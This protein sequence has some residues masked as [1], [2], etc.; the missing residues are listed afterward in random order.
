MPFADHARLPDLLPAGG[1][2]T[3]A[4]P[5]SGACARHRPRPV[6]STNAGAAPLFPGVA[7]RSARARRIRRPGGRLHHR[8][9]RRGRVGDGTSRAFFL[10]RPVGGRHDRAM[11]WRDIMR[12]GSSGWCSR[13]LRRGSRIRACSKCGG[14]P[15]STEGLVGDRTG[16]DGTILFVRREMLPADSIRATLLATDATGY[17]GCCA[18]IR[19][20][21][22]RPLL[23][24]ITFP[25]W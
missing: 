16:S 25:H 17:A 21:D 23:P 18:A 9:T 22:H 6:G 2:C 11:A 1:L 5:G 12:N 7:A 10:L 13:T 4:A 14:R 20:M 8:P 15:S 3:E 24:G 19:D